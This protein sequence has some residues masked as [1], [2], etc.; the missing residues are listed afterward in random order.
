[1]P[2]I[3]HSLIKRNQELMHSMRQSRNALRSKQGYIRN[4]GMDVTNATIAE[5]TRQIGNLLKANSIL[6]SHHSH[7]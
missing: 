5:W 2:N 3:P 1:M 7:A 4:G 6:R